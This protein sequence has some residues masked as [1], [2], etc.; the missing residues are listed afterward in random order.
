MFG[1][2]RPR[3]TNRS[4]LTG[5][6]HIEWLP[7]EMRDRL[8]SVTFPMWRRPC[9]KV[10]LLDV[11]QLAPE[12]LEWVWRIREFEGPMSLTNWV[13]AF[14]G[15]PYSKTGRCLCAIAKWFGSVAK[16]RTSFGWMRSHPMSL[17]RRTRMSPSWMLSTAPLGPLAPSLSHRKLATSL[18]RSVPRL[19]RQTSP[20]CDLQ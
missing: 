15:S 19:G 20:T 11:L 3:D 18:A 14:G 16:S 1:A 5:G 7:V 13:P 12:P 4:R 2:P 17:T 9:N 6:N 10:Q 8:F